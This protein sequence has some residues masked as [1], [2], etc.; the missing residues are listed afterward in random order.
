MPIEGELPACIVPFA[1]LNRRLKASKHPTCSLSLSDDGERLILNGGRVE[2]ALQTSPVEEFPPVSDAYV[3]DTVTADAA[4][5][6]G[7]LRIV[8][9]AMARETSRYAIDGVLLESDDQGTRLVATDV[10]ADTV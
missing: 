4:E 3:G 5:L 9:L 8:S 7:A 1:G 2:H 6:V 10:R